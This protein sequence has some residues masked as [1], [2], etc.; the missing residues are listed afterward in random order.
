MPRLAS[1]RAVTKTPGH[2]RIGLIMNT[3]THVLLDIR[4]DLL[5][6]ELVNIL[7]YSCL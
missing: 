1:P 5:R 6:H 3:Y 7:N 2:S 4:G